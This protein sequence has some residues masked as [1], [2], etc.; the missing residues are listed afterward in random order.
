LYVITSF[1]TP[2]RNRAGD[3]NHEPNHF[4]EQSDQPYQPIANLAQT[5]ESVVFN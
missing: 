1:I 3:L 4:T 5:S 2:S